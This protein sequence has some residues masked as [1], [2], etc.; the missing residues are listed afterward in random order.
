[1][2]QRQRRAPLVYDAVTRTVQ[3]LDARIVRVPSDVAH[4]HA[5]TQSLLTQ[6]QVRASLL[7]HCVRA[8]VHLAVYLCVYVESK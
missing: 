4:A 1:M 2:A 6:C 5:A 7:L 3:A 8:L